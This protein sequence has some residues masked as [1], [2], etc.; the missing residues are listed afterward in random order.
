MT[1]G[2][3]VATE[4][5]R[6]GIAFADKINSKI[7][8]SL[9]CAIMPADPHAGIDEFRATQG[10]EAKIRY[11]IGHI[12]SGSITPADHDRNRQTIRYK[13]IDQQVAA[14]DKDQGFLG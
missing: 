12:I 2:S 9:R 10:L 14:F 6:R 13:L 8:E 4:E 5:R 7:H 1:T 3:Y 11:G